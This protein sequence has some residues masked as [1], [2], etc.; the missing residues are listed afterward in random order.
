MTNILL[1]WHLRSKEFFSVWKTKS[2]PS[3]SVYHFW[4]T[5]FFS[6]DLR[7]KFPKKKMINLLLLL[8]VHFER[9]TTFDNRPTNR[10]TTSRKSFFWQT[11]F[12][13]HTIKW[14]EMFHGYNV[15]AVEEL[16]RKNKIIIKVWIDSKKSSKINSKRNW[17]A[18]LTSSSCM[19]KIN[20]ASI[21]DRSNCEWCK[22]WTGADH[23]LKKKV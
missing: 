14:M 17:L 21:N 22:T 5:H 18:I 1:R 6:L 9:S 4:L 3:P 20:F 13:D 19:S 2:S 12:T 10:T 11:Y 7:P 23:F 8:V 16:G 15:A